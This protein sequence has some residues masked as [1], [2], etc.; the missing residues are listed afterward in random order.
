MQTFFQYIRNSW[1]ELN[2]V[3]WPTRDEVLQATQ[4]TLLFVIFTIIFLMLTDATVGQL[5]DLII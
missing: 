1:A 5:V 3:T 2:R 4:A